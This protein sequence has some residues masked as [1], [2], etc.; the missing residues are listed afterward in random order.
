MFQRKMKLDSVVSGILMELVVNGLCESFCYLCF[1][2]A[3]I[4]LP[5]LFIEPCGHLLRRGCSLGSLV[6]D[7]SLCFCHFPI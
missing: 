4:L 7:V 1:T 5:C 3:F 2:F 6:C